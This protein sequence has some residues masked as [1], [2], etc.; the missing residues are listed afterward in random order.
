MD[1][2]CWTKQIL[3]AADVGEKSPDFAIK[4]VYCISLFVSFWNKSDLEVKM[5]PDFA[6]NRVYCIS[7]FCIFL[8]QE[9]PWSK[10]VLVKL[11]SRLPTFGWH[12]RSAWPSLENHRGLSPDF[13]GWYYSHAC[14]KIE[15][16][17]CITNVYAHTHAHT[18]TNTHTHTHQRWLE[19]LHTERYKKA[20]LSQSQQMQHSSCH[21]V[22][23][24]AWPLVDQPSKLFFSGLFVWTF[25]NLSFLGNI[26]IHF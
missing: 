19:H 26:F 8:K 12:S 17:K 18:H 11:E 7:L 21:P 23:T 22:V 3:N 16:W 4:R 20:S 24:A 2:N 10:D 6:I 14:C 15:G 25:V 1:Q 5:S 13:I 9:R